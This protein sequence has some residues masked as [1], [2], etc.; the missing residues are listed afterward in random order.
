MFPLDPAVSRG[1]QRFR[2]WK[3]LSFIGDR[4]LGIESGGIHRIFRN[5][6][7]FHHKLRKPISAIWGILKASATV[8]DYVAKHARLRK[9][10]HKKAVSR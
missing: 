1:S 5:K 9:K 6:S 8:D 4:R 3:P 2:S 10:P 7:S